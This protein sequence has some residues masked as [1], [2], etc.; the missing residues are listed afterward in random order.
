MIDKNK[1]VLVLG[2]YGRCGKQLIQL[3]EK[4]G[5]DNLLFPTHT[6]C[7]LLNEYSYE[8]YFYEA[9]PEYVINLAAKITNLN[10]CN[11]YPAS[12]CRETVLMNTSVLEMCQKYEVQKLINIISSC[13]YDGETSLLKE[14]DFFKGSPHPSIMAHG[15]A[16]RYVYFLGSSYAK[17]YHMNVVN[18]AFN[19]FFGGGNW[20][21]PA[22]L[23]FLDSLIVKIVD[24]KLFKYKT[25]EIWG[26]GKPRREVLYTKDAVEGILRVFE[27]YD[28]PELIN[29]GTGVDYNITEYAEMIR[30]IVNWKG[31]FVYLTDKPDGQMQKI[32]SIEKQQKLLNWIPSTNICDAIQETVNEYK[33]FCKN[34]ERRSY[35]LE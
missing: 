7:N 10:L 13:A 28:S 33:Q 5:Y 9:K 1:K 25:V 11:Q 3:L 12:I 6:F 23:K 17:Q 14:E 29:I 35:R 26:S 27:Q 34:K 18:I 22:S 15:L 21:K 2:A 24:A 30:D 32:F 16:K 4:S 8:Q 20:S 31:E 19:T